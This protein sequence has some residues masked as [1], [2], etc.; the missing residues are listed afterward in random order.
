MWIELIRQARGNSDNK[1]EMKES[2]DEIHGRSFLLL[3]HRLDKGKQNMGSPAKRTR[4]TPRG[5][6]R[7]QREGRGR[8]K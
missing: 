5:D 7:P 8:K 2:G 6:I 4:S 3:R 1:E